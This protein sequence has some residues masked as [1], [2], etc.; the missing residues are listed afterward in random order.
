VKAMQIPSFFKA[1]KSRKFNYTPLY[2][3]E[4]D[5]QLKKR[6]QKH[7]QNEQASNNLR[8]NLQHEWRSAQRKH[9]GKSSNRTVLIIAAILS[10]I[11]YLLL[12]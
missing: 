6:I 7:E 2:Y 4:R 9:K 1:H 5:E 12:R 11:A 3:N 8:T 10:I